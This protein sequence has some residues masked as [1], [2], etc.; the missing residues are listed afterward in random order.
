[1]I[2]RQQNEAPSSASSAPSVAKPTVFRGTSVAILEARARDGDTIEDS[3]L[4]AIER[5]TPILRGRKGLTFRRCKFH[6]TLP[7]AG[8][9]LIDCR[10]V[11][12]VLPDPVEAEEMHVVPRSELIE[13][14]E[15]ARDG[16]KTDVTEFCRRQG[17]DAAAVVASA[18]PPVPSA[19]EPEVRP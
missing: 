4:T 17:L 14:V 2:E 1:M 15:A 13:I 10:S 11:E 8:S 19:R 12:T 7:P 16:R 9:R 3:T 6:R 18:Q 5:G